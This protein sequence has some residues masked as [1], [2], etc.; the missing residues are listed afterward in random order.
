M[1][2]LGEKI[3]ALRTERDLTQSDLARALGHKHSAAVCNW[4]NDVNKPSKSNLYKLS[5]FFTIPVS[6]FDEETGHV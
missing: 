5:K 6:F 1:K 2:T 4:E 3:T